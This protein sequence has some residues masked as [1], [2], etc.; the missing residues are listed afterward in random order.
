MDR[1]IHISCKT[2]A[3]RKCR[4]W[5]NHIPH[6]LISFQSIWGRSFQQTLVNLHCLQVTLNNWSRMRCPQFFWVLYE[7]SW[8]SLIEFN[9]T[10]SVSPKSVIIA[11]PSF[12]TAKCFSGSPY[13]TSL[14]EAL[15]T[16]AC[17]C[18]CSYC[19]SLLIIITRLL[20]LNVFLEPQGFLV[21]SWFVRQFEFWWFAYFYK[22]AYNTT[23]T[24]QMEFVSHFSGERQA[25]RTL[26][27]SVW[28][29]KWKYSVLQDRPCF[30]TILTNWLLN[31]SL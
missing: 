10:F 17:I 11:F 8:T 29:G 21:H 14:E 28:K 9:P 25:L 12:V 20:Y 6:F 2:P 24:F 26:S 15:I 18:A 4:G 16:W 22:T 1:W 5:W 30:N 3:R 13:F 31:I 23:L 27:A 19:W 7:I